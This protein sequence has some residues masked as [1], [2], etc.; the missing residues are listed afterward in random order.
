MFQLPNLRSTISRYQ[1]KSFNIAIKEDVTFVAKAI[2]RNKAT[3]QAMETKEERDVGCT[4][5]LQ[6]VVSDQ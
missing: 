6:W 2:P 3:H 5:A 1:S 4:G